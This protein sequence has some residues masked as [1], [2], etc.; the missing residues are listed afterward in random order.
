MAG[1]E[2]RILLPTLIAA[3]GA[4]VLGEREDYGGYSEQL[5]GAF[6][7]KP[8]YPEFLND[9]EFHALMRYVATL[10]LKRMSMEASLKHE[11]ESAPPYRWFYWLGCFG[12]VFPFL[13]MSGSS[14]G[15]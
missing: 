14:G 12:V 8:P 1:V 3:W 9:D 4:Y 5:I 10:L 13:S 6:A 2:Q 7:A 15:I 11:G